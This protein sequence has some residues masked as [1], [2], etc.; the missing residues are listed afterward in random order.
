MMLE[1]QEIGGAGRE[2]F[3]QD[4]NPEIISHVAFVCVCVLGGTES[5][6]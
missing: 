1:D 5:Q 6:E 2:R 4:Q 3:D